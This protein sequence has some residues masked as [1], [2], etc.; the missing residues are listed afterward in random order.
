LQ[1]FYAARQ[2]AMRLARRA[3]LADINAAFAGGEA[4]RDLDQALGD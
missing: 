3:R 2:S 1:L 4:A